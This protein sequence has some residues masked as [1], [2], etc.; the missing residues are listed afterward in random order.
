M[1]EVKSFCRFCMPFC[2]TKVTLDDND[3]IVSVKGDRDDLMTSGYICFKG[4]QTPASFSA[5][6]RVLYPMKRQPDGTFTRIGF[7]QALDEIAA[8]LRNIIQQ[9]GPEAVAGYRG[10]GSL[11][12]ASATS[13]VPAFLGAIGSHKHFTTYTIDQS[14][15]SIALG[16]IGMWNAPRHPLHDSDVRLMFGV[17]PLVSLATSYFDM[18]NPTKRM[19]DARARGMKLIV[20]DPR[21][22]ETANYAD[23]FLQP[24]PG[25]DPTVAAGLI[26]IILREGWEDKAF[27]AANV[28][29]MD[30]LRSAV[31]PY[32][33]DYVAKRAGIDADDLYRAARLFA[34]ECQRGGG[35]TGT[36]PSM[37]PHSNLT[38]HLVETLNVICGRFMREGEKVANPGVLRARQTHRAQV[39]AAPRWWESSYKSRIGGFGMLGDEMMSGILSDEILEPGEGQ[40]RALFAHGSNLANI[41]PDQRKM[42]RA[43]QSLE[44]LVNVDPYMNETSRLAHY[45]LPTKMGY[46]REDL[47]MFFYESLYAEPYARYTPAISAPPPGSELVDD[48]EIFWGL[49]KRLDLQLTYDGVPLDMSS[50]PTTDSLLALV[51]RHAPVPFEELKAMELGGIFDVDP[52]YVEAADPGH[53]DRFTVMPADVAVEMAQVYRQTV[54]HGAYVSHGQVFTHRLATRRLRDVQNSSHRN[55]PAIRERMP[56]NYAYL[57][58][59][60]LAVLGIEEGDRIEITSDAGSIP[61]EV[62]ADNTVRPGVV[63]ITHGWGTLPGETDYQRDGSNTGLLISTDRDLDPINAMPR[64]SAIPVNVRPLIKFTELHETQITSAA[65]A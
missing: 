19:K 13:M 3:Q 48:W 64:M 4:V 23:V 20:I 35:S 55:V 7:E 53:P 9:Q 58:P 39:T 46:E 44:L 59:D 24:Y 28:A 51:A 38:E 43:L 40:V 34:H 22:T 57:H 63:S 41:M 16:R 45:I 36:G 18:T 32:V 33:P 5:P 26:H 56:Y 11:L 42:V 8:K 31:A 62:K 27:C 52:L 17:N 21:R 15:K 30:A 47:T 50:Q 49:A 6:D 29:D 2:G 12:N 10:A 61:A 37:A 60:E 1:R 14:A 25:E 65:M 54:S